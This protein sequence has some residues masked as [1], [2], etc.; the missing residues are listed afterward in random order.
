MG[1]N[2]R[3]A[4]Y[5]EDVDKKAVESEWNE[6]VKH[7]CYEEGGGGLLHS[8][9]WLDHI[10][11]DE[12]EAEEYIKSH[13]KGWYDQLAVKF[14]EYPKL[15]PSK[16]L[17]TLRK[18]RTAEQ[19]KYSS[20]VKA[21]SVSTFKAEYIGCPQCGSKLKKEL[22]RGDWCPLCR[23]ELRSKTTNETITRYSNKICELDKQ[24]RAEE[25]KME[26]KNIKN[27]K[28]KW[29]VKIEYHT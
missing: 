18:R 3:H 16:T 2:I 22:L 14:R 4:V 20:Y 28:I 23:A 19:E 6:K 29:L 10:C 21:H 1:H 13:D 11:K 5:P 27:T 24:I 7:I 8:I 25:K 9:R 15:E 26:E 17:L 12:E